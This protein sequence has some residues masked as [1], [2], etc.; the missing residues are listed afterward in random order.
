MKKG[1]FTVR[2]VFAHCSFTLRYARKNR[3]D[4]QNPKSMFCEENAYRDA[5]V[6]A[7][8]GGIQDLPRSAYRPYILGFY[9]VDG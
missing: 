9:L 6:A 3:L 7:T 5:V 2:S 8:K 1:T 4:P